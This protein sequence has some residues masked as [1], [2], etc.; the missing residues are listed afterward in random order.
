MKKFI[1]EAMSENGTISIKRCVLVWALVLFTAELVVNGIGKQR[2]LEPELR[3]Q[4]FE[5]MCITL[6]AVVGINVFNGYKD[7]K[8]VQS[9]NNAQVGASS[10]PPA[11]TMVVETK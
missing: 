11:P 10:P 3:S 1:R 5:F 9:N 8:I 7:I 6:G 2:V 4:L